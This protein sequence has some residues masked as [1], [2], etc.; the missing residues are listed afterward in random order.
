MLFSQ[1]VHLYILY[2]V[3]G[4]IVSATEDMLSPVALGMLKK[5]FDSIDTDHSK[6]ISLDEFKAA[7][8][9][10]SIPVTNE[11]IKDFLNRSSDGVVTFEA[12]CDYYLQRLGQVFS[13]F[14]LDNSG[15]INVSELGTVFQKLGVTL[16]ERELQMIISQADKD[17]NGEVNFTEFCEFFATLPSPDVRSVVRQWAAGI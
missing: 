17:A 14:D 6:T 2:V 16:S 13:H 7:C 10:L 12:F 5:L 15:E 9:K 8:H 3:P 4:I 11:T 1:L